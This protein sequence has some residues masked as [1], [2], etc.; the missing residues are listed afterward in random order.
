M[1]LD[2]KKLLDQL[3]CPMISGIYFADGTITALDGYPETGL[4]IA[5]RVKSDMKLLE[6]EEVPFA[7]LFE[8]NRFEVAT[9]GLL[10]RAVTGLGKVKDI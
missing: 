7:T 5:P 2:F 8:S 3:E 6:E 10:I 1:A 4:T 9:E